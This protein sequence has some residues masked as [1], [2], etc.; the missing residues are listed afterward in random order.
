MTAVEVSVGPYFVASPDNISCDVRVP[1][2]LFADEEEGRLHA[3]ALEH[4][5]HP[6][7]R[8]CVGA[9][10]EREDDVVRARSTDERPE[11]AL[12]TRRSRERGRHIR[13]V[14][15]RAKCGT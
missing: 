9:I 4:V 11:R 14:H 7:R 8:D 5:E 2:D 10:V 13:S 15:C 3:E 1:L 6:R 12:T